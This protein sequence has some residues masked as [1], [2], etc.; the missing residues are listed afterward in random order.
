MGGLA[1]KLAA[2][3]KAKTGAKVR[4]IEFSLMQRSAAHLASQTD[5]DEAFLAGK[6]AVEK[7][8]AGESGKMVGFARETVNGKYKCVIELQPLTVTANAEKKMPRE[9]INEAG[10]NVTQELIDYVLPLIQGENTRELINGL[11]RFAKLKKIKA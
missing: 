8:V 9:W 3:V 10:T 2:A 5:I 6:T 11:P 1:V 4:P 7:A